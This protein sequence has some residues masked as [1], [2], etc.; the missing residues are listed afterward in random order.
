MVFLKLFLFR[1]YT[2]LSTIY[3]YFFLLKINRNSHFT[4]IGYE[5]LKLKTTRSSVA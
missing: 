3:E 5:K 2:S 4:D 1:I